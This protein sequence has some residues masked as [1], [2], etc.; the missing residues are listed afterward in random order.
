MTFRKE[1]ILVGHEIQYFKSLTSNVRR[2]DE[3]DLVSV[4]Q[5]F[6]VEIAERQ[7]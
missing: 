1:N 6:R 2:R 4:I 7:G 5:G 3:E